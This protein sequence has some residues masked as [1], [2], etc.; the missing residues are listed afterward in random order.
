MNPGPPIAPFD[1]SLKHLAKRGDYCDKNRD[2]LYGNGSVRCPTVHRTQKMNQNKNSNHG[3]IP[4]DN[5]YSWV[6]F[7]L[8]Y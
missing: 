8:V 5:G 4:D 7:F 1:L 2:C 3:S 6:F